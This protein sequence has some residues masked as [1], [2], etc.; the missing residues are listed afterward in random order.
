MTNNKESKECPKC[1]SNSLT[2]YGNNTGYTVTD[3]HSE[4][5]EIF[6]CNACG[7]EFSKNFNNED[8][9]NWQSIKKVREVNE[10]KIL[11]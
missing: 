10:S 3:I 8:T 9:G 2:I 1:K 6:K 5:F 7:Y 4:Y 11:R